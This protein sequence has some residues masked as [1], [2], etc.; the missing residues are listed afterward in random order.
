MTASGISWTTS[1]PSCSG[2]NSRAA[3]QLAPQLEEMPAQADEVMKAEVEALRAELS[4]TQARVTAL[5]ESERALKDRSV[6]LWFYGKIIVFEKTRIA[7]ESVA[8]HS[9]EVNVII[10]ERLV[11]YYG[12]L[13]TKARVDTMDAL[14]TL[15]P[16]NS[17]PELKNKILFSVIVVRVW[18]QPPRLT[19]LRTSVF[20]LLHLITI[21]LFLTQ[22]IKIHIPAYLLSNLFVYSFLSL[23]VLVL[24]L[25][26][27]IRAVITSAKAIRRLIFKDHFGET[28]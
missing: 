11:Q 22:L 27:L 26:I 23:S 2:C 15:V 13:Y 9:L 14:D 20:S 4:R 1:V 19:L 21:R 3:L 17:A 25:S 6:F 8:S 7:Q 5:Q 12:N 24:S 28:S 10:G 18:L 16:L